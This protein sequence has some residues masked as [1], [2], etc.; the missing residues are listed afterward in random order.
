MTADAESAQWSCRDRA[1]PNCEGRPWKMETKRPSRRAIGALRAAGNYYVIVCA[2]CQHP[3]GLHVIIE[4]EPRVTRCRCCTQCTF[5][6][7]GEYGLWSDA[8][9]REM[10]R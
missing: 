6:V 7:D 9:T 4:W 2:A 8:M 1:R 5:Y 3:G 10:A